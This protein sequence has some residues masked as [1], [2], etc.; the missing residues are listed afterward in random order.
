MTRS[1]SAVL[2]KATAVRTAAVT[3]GLLTTAGAFAPVALA[4]ETTAPTGT[5]D[6][7]T[8]A[9]ATTSS[10]PTTVLTPEPAPTATAT[11]TTTAPT[12]S[13]AP[14]TPTTSAA[15][16]PTSTGSPQTVSVTPPGGSYGTGKLYPELQAPEDAGID[17][18][19]I[20]PTGAQVR[21]SYSRLAGD[22]SAQPEDVCTFQ[23]DR[24][25]FGIGTTCV[26]PEDTDIPLSGYG[27]GVAYVPADSVFT[28]TLVKQP[29]SGQ[30]LLLPGSSVTTQG[31]STA[32][33]GPNPFPMVS[34]PLVAESGYRQIRITGA[35]A[36]AGF[37]LCPVADWDCS[38]DDSSDPG[39]I[40]PGSDL[41]TL[42]NVDED[43]FETV[44]TDGSGTATFD[45]AYRPGRYTLFQT[46]APAGQTFDPTAALTVD[47]GIATS[48]AERDTPAL[49]DLGTPAPAP[50]TPTT[51]APAPSTPATGA[52]TTTA[53]VSGTPAA[54]SVAAAS[55]APGGLAYTGTDV[56]PLLAAGGGLLAAG[57]A[58]V[59]VAARRRSA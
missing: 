23:P 27:D 33:G 13:E 25:W 40:D 57:A 9:P 39:T 37:R 50:V 14:T 58:A 24:S 51:S 53:P 55:V 2:P 54:T 1:S 12:T 20:D 41:I 5:T 15:T 38:A 10:G 52:P 3:M 6:P 22:P 8:T 31:H 48:L 49:L 21:L 30:L 47:V 43:G 17:P 26:F 36:H 18:G 28:L 42:M 59:T 44:T 34:V 16:A 56:L 29:D 11:P 7:T 46:S 4:E 35:P 45:G 32:A 19:E